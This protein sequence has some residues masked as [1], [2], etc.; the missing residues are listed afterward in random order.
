MSKPLSKPLSTALTGNSVR[1]LLAGLAFFAAPPAIVGVAISLRTA[2][3]VDSRAVVGARIRVHLPA[4][5]AASERRGVDLALLLAVASV[6]SAGRADARSG[7]GAVGLM[8]LMPATARELAAEEGRGPPDL[9]DPATSLDLGAKYLARQIARFEGRRETRELALCAYNAGPGAVQ[10]WLDEDPLEP[11][12]P[13][14]APEDADP[15]LGRW[16]PYGETRAFV[17]RVSEW[18]EHWAAYLAGTGDR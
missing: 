12:A 10:R 11:L 13:G 6:E 4:A 14:A 18:R 1:A 9:L 17:R 16:I 5:R 8:Q 2:G 15:H 7:A 3:R